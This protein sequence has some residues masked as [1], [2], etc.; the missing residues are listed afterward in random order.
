MGARVNQGDISAAAHY[1]GAVDHQRAGASMRW[2]NAPTLTLDTD[3]GSQEKVAPPDGSDDTGWRTVQREGGARFG[4][5]SGSSVARRRG[6]GQG[7]WENG[8]DGRMRHVRACVRFGKDS[9]WGFL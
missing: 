6:C 9:T 3:G 2:H 7:S 5:N 4:S 8:I 1:G